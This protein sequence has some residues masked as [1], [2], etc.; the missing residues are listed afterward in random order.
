MGNMFLFA[1]EQKC[2]LALR[3]WNIYQAAWCKLFS[4]SWRNVVETGCQSGLGESKHSF[5]INLS[6]STTSLCDSWTT[7]SWIYTVR[8]AHRQYITSCSNI[9]TG[10]CQLSCRRMCLLECHVLTKIHVALV[11]FLVTFCNS[12]YVFGD[13]TLSVLPVLSLQSPVQ[14]F[15]MALHRLYLLSHLYTSQTSLFV[16]ERVPLRVFSHHH[17]CCSNEWTGKG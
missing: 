13:C 8:L 3:Y 16:S 12:S 10:F 2:L 5:I 17:L 7:C 11:C 1:D 6:P 4:D 14:L 9:A 15:M